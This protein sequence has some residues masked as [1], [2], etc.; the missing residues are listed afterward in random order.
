MAATPETITLRFYG[1]L[2]ELAG[3]EAEEKALHKSIT[4]G[5][6]LE[7]IRRDR[8][9]FRRLSMTI[10]CNDRNV[11]RQHIVEPGDVVDVFPPFAGG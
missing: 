4:A 2:A 9:V 7:E 11:S 10:A 6:L 3:T 8:P 1:Q 5:E